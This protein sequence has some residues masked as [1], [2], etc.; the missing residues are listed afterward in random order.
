MKNRKVFEVL[1]DDA[2]PRGHCF[3]DAKIVI[4]VMANLPRGSSRELQLAD[5]EQFFERNLRDR[6]CCYSAFAKI[7]R[8][9]AK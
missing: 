2:L 5:L 3:D 9:K 8:R 1:L 4:V 6:G 7:R